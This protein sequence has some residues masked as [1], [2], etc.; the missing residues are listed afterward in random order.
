MALNDND[1]VFID[2][3]VDDAA[4]RISASFKD[5]VKS[6]PLPAE[7][8]G[9]AGSKKTG[10]DDDKP[11]KLGSKLQELAKAIGGL[12]IAQK[13]A[14]KGL[15]MWGERFAFQDQNAGRLIATNQQSILQTREFVDTL[16]S[17]NLSLAE[18][19]RV[20]N[21]GM[22]AGLRS[23]KAPQL[24]FL[25]HVG[26]LGGS[27]EMAAKQ[28]AFM[29]Q[30]VG[31]STR[32]SVSLGNSINGMAMHTGESM[33]LLRKAIAEMSQN[34]I[35][36]AGVF[37][38][39]SGA[40]WTSAIA[41]LQ[42][43]VSQENRAGLK[44][45]L[46][47]YAP[48]SM[49]RLIKLNQMAPGLGQMGERAF[50]S[51]DEEQMV[52]F[53]KVLAESIV[54]QQSRAQGNIGRSQFVLKDVLGVGMGMLPAAREIA[55]GPVLSGSEAQ[56]QLE[57]TK[58]DILGLSTGKAKTRFNT[59]MHAE[60]TALATQATQAFGAVMEGLADS[61]TFTSIAGHGLYAAGALKVVGDMAATAATALGFLTLTGGTAAI[62]TGV[63]A[64]AGGAA[65]GGG[66]ILGGKA[67][68]GGGAVAAGQT[69]SRIWGNLGKLGKTGHPFARGLHGA[70]LT[71]STAG[72]HIAGTLSTQGAMNAAR[73]GQMA[74]G[75][76]PWMAGAMVGKDAFDVVAGTDGGATGE[77]IGGTIGGAVGA[78]GFLGGPLLGALTMTAGNMLGNAI[79][80]QFDS[81]ESSPAD[82][83]A[84]LQASNLQAAGA[85]TIESSQLITSYLESIRE[86]TAKTADNTYEM[87]NQQ[88]ITNQLL[89]INSD[90]IID[91]NQN[92]RLAGVKPGTTHKSKA[93]DE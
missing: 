34:I 37:G 79:G 59:A 56:A 50:Q 53:G 25:S 86:H 70:N 90:G 88:N 28:Q 32:Q 24:D 71:T 30:A 3:L 4:F 17:N 74:R 47:A 41:R 20:L 13:A 63:G 9:A 52:R 67:V 39:D 66:A 1:K 73:A 22:N 40:S 46:E 11:E 60:T 82:A 29:T 45:M 75:A 93:E 76:A 81:E 27:I 69:H 21:A 58:T 35:E 42:G 6:I 51:G 23:M 10:G 80:S 12:K 15:D 44:S 14:S 31:L 26:M 84:E 77:N 83:N 72:R 18:G 78:L 68:L 8:A 2:K 55:G 91:L 49:D 64:L 62:T 36:V 33:D 5:A 43:S 85:A 89:D 38:A 92:L 87:A 57:A 19:T 54:L 48:T 7:G 61:E 65:L 16:K